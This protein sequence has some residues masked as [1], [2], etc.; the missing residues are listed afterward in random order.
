MRHLLPLAML[1][2]LLCTLWA[3]F[4]PATKRPDRCELL[5]QAVICTIERPR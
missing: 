3:I 1:F 4:R 2:L 5:Q